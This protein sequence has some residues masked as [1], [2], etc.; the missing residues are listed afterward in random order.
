MSDVQLG[1]GLIGIGRPWGHIRGEVP[2]EAEVM[3]LLEGA[4]ELGV[5]YFDTA[6]SYGLSE[7]RLGR[8][9]R[10]C[11]APLTIA[12]KFGEH[13]D[14][15]KNEPFVDHSFDALRRSLDESLAR[16]GRIDVLQLHKTTPAVLASSDLARAWEY[17]ASLGIT[18][19][20]AS[21]SDNE[22]ACRSLAEPSYRVLQLPF[23]VRNPAFGEVIGQAAAR[24]VIV[25][26]N[27]PF[28]MGAMRHESPVDPADAFRCILAL[29][30][31]GVVLTG[32][33]S[34]AHL[35]ENWS[36]FLAARQTAG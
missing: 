27:R 30:F 36:G 8:F 18:R 4:V 1:L 34:L 32:T 17:A 10:T 3:A 22:S 33:R 16:L 25:A 28:A 6:P 26:V 11:T 23:N 19:I 15:A 5:Q 24:G 9:L 14:T 21:V 29:D 35:R 7:E 2:P 12:T 31:R 13:W 20:G